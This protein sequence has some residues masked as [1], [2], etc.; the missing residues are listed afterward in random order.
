MQDTA[1]VEH[2]C[3]KCGKT[4]MAMETETVYCPCNRLTGKFTP[5]TVGRSQ[6]LAKEAR[7]K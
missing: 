2:R 4:W 7:S 5:M 1:R 3:R 6:A